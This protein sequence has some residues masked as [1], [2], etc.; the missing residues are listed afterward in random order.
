MLIS[1]FNEENLLIIHHKLPSSSAQNTVLVYCEQILWGNLIYCVSEDTCCGGRLIELFILTFHGIN[2]SYLAHF[3]E[4]KL[5]NSAIICRLT[6]VQA[7]LKSFGLKLH[8]LGLHCHSPQVCRNIRWHW[9][10]HQ[11]VKNKSSEFYSVPCWRENQII[12]GTL[13]CWYCSNCLDIFP[14]IKI[15]RCLGYLCNAQDAPWGYATF[16]YP[17]VP[18][19]RCSTNFRIGGRGFGSPLK[20]MEAHVAIPGVSPAL[21]SAH[22]TWPRCWTCVGQSGLSTMMSSK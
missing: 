3:S 12:K 9:L 18:D 4:A 8:C 5:S 14:T 16:C 17:T 11:E 10:Q 13:W 21:E 6:P 7:L 2:I 20:F 22:R 1:F 19:P 15:W